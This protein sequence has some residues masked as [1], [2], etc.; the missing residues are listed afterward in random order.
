MGKTGYD[1]WR[2]RRDSVGSLGVNIYLR[3]YIYGMD[4]QVL[5]PG[6]GGASLAESAFM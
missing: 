5:I 4:I 2:L 6:K 3:M 1:K